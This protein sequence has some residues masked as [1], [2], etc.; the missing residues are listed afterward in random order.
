MLLD[1]LRPGG[2]G[3]GGRP[4]SAPDG[5][6][7]QQQPEAAHLG[8]L[9]QPPGAVLPAGKPLALEPPAGECGVLQGIG[10]EARWMPERQVQPN[11]RVPSRMPRIQ[12][13]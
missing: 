2:P 11:S 7:E 1:G 3:S 5:I 10:N 4:G 12:T 6:G 9:A 13:R 8:A